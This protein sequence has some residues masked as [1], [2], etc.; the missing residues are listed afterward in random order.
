MMLPSLH[1]LIDLDPRYLAQ[2][3][4]PWAQGI[5]GAELDA[6]LSTLPPDGRRALEANISDETHRF[7]ASESSAL[8]SPA[9]PKA[10]ALK[11]L[12][13]YFW[14]I[15]YQRY[16]K[17]YEDFS[18]CQ[19]FPFTDLFP[20]ASLAGRKVLDIAAGTGKL[21]LHVAKYA[22]HVV[23]VDPAA[24]LLEVLSRKASACNLN[25]ELGAFAALPL[26]DAS[27]DVVVSNLGFQISEERG[28]ERGLAEMVR[29]LRP[30]GE[31]R[32]TVGSYRT[33]AWLRNRG[34]HEIA[35]HRPIQWTLPAREALTP[36]LQVLLRS[37][38]V[39]VAPGVRLVDRWLFVRP[40]PSAARV[41]ASL[42]ALAAGARPATV[43][44]RCAPWRPL[45]CS[46][47][48]RRY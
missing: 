35:T 34:F 19:T 8:S 13:T 25:C 38:G 40:K 11:V 17:D 16:P 29:V 24:P 44:D 31:I 37:I 4:Q 48:V 15:V 27:V 26:S 43:F 28:G 20:A 10:A 23:A 18:A 14:E 2:N 39:P 12:A 22:N 46:S 33:E 21:T 42:A 32:L 30:G 1:D 6:A 41:R 7:L 47:L 5:S 3:F 45:G 36:V 9:E